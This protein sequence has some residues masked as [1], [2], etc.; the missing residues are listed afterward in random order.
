[1]EHV[2]KN[3][4][5]QSFKI[6]MAYR[7]AIGV[8]DVELV[9]VL[10]VAHGLGALVTSHCEHGDAVVALQTRLAN[11]RQAG[12]EV[13]PDEP[14]HV[15]RGRGD[16]PGHPAGAR[17]GRRPQRAHEPGEGLAAHL[18]RAPHLQGV[19][20]RG[21]PRARRGP[22]GDGRDVP[23]VPAAGRLRVRQARLRGRGVRDE[24]S[25]S[26]E[27]SPG[28]PL[29]RDGRTARIQTVATDHCPFR[30]ADQK[31]AGKDDFRK[32]PNG[33]A[34]VENRMGLM[35]TYGVADGPHLAAAVRRR[36]VDAGGE[37]LQHV[38]AQ[39]DHRGRLGRRLLPLRSQGR[40]RRSPR[41]RTT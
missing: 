25:D 13:P 35:Y 8:D 24:P 40:R 7:G 36:D 22:E 20:G 5:I 29:E 19:D 11:A 38:P 41:R 17:R 30:Q 15:P 33:A 18:H 12:A 21:V 9:Q 37:D 1:M 23:A 34:G 4:G 32:I 28:V 31:I 16:Q 27:G 10:D 3:D 14:A 2:F 6:F 26:A 39:G